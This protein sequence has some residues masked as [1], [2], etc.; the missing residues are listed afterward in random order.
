MLVLTAA[1]VLY[2]KF[3]LARKPATTAAES[4]KSSPPPHPFTESPSQRQAENALSFQKEMAWRRYFQPSAECERPPTWADQV[5]CGNQYASAR[6][7]FES[8][9][10]L[11]HTSQTTGTRTR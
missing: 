6:Q 5:A 9:W 1:W 4:A 2:A 8:Q 11:D 10:K 7:A 3:S